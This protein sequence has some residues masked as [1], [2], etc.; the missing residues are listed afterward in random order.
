MTDKEQVKKAY[1]QANQELEQKNVER[2][3]DIVLDTLKAI[4][5]YSNGIRQLKEK[6]AEYI[7]KIDKE[8]SEH[9]KEVRTLKMDLDDLKS[10]KLERIEERQRLDPEAKR[11]SVIIIERIVEREIPVPYPQPWPMPQPLP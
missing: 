11:T 2:I 4:D 10:G 5:T 7:K 3:K 9:E 8:I 6:K 1:Q